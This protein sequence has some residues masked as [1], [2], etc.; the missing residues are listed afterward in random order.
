MWQIERSEQG[1]LTRPADLD[2]CPFRHPS[3]CRPG[4]VER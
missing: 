3:F 2:F 1:G 4:R